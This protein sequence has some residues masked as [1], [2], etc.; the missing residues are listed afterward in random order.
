MR[1]VSLASAFSVRASVLSASPSGAPSKAY[2]LVRD[3]LA[4]SAVEGHLVPVLGH[5]RVAPLAA[6]PQ[7]NLGDRDLAPLALQAT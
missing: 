5:H 2:P 6:D 7:V 3:D 4:V 1:I